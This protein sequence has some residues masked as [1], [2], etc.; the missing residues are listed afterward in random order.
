MLASGKMVTVM[1]S[2]ST[3]SLSGKHYHVSDLTPYSSA[4]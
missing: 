1:L 4:Q 2:N 3:V